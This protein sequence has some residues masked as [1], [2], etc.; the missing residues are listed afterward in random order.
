VASVLLEPGYAFRGGRIVGERSA[1]HVMSFEIDG[2]RRQAFSIGSSEHFALP[3]L[4]PLA[5]GAGV[6]PVQA[7]LTDVAVYLGW[8][9]GA[10]RLVQAA[11][12]LATPLGRLA[13]VRRVLDG[14]AR[15]IQ[16]SR[17][18]PSAAKTIRSD[19]VAVAGDAGADG[20]VEPRPRNRCVRRRAR[21][22]IRIAHDPEQPLAARLSRFRD[23]VQVQT[24]A[25]ERGGIAA[26]LADKRPELAV[27][28]R[29]RRRPPRLGGGMGGPGRRDAIGRHETSGAHGVGVGWAR[30]GVFEAL[31]G[32]VPKGGPEN[33]GPSERSGTT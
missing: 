15:R 19:V 16:R 4:R 12:V 11:S 25:L 8:F 6:A 32:V 3:R 30:P 24:D 29:Q 2:K 26:E 7:P 27:C 28:S 10:T 21:V 14:Q 23:P 18:Q 31:S 5:A 20:T 22:L 1:A 33:E 9:G 13:G 17:A